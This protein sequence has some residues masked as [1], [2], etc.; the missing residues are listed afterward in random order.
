MKKSKCLQIV[1]TVN[2]VGNGTG[3]YE[4]MIRNEAVNHMGNP[5]SDYMMSIT[6]VKVINEVKK[7]SPDHS[8]GN[9]SGTMA[10]ILAFSSW[11]EAKPKYT[12]VYETRGILYI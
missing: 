5:I 1:W 9:I 3:K 8:S 6:H 7:P 4:E 10:D 12:S 11:V 2:Q